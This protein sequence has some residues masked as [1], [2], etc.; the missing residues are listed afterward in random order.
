MSSIEQAEIA[1][2][3]LQNIQL[4]AAKAKSHSVRTAEIIATMRSATVFNRL[5]DKCVEQADQ[6]GISEPTLPRIRR[7]PRRLD[8]GANTASFD[9]PR[10]YFRKNF[11]ELVDCAVAAINSRFNTPGLDVACAV[12]RLLLGRS[13]WKSD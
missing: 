10:D 3:A 1:N 2:T 13:W 11:F 7:P 8:D 9:D 12:E 6:W 5:Y 4:T